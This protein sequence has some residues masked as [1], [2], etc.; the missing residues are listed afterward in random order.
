M[1]KAEMRR[2]QAADAKARRTERGSSHV[3][4]VNASLDR[5]RCT[6]AVEVKEL[7]LPCGLKGREPRPRTGRNEDVREFDVEGEPVEAALGYDAGVSS[8]VEGCMR[9]HDDWEDGVAVDV[10]GVGELSSELDAREASEVK[11]S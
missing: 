3:L 9:R 11:I 2:Q 8:M 6:N 7:E 1:E 4:R 5:S 10:E